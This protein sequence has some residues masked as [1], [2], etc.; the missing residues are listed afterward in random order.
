MYRHELAHI[1]KESTAVRRG[2]ELQLLNRRIEDV[3]NDLQINQV[4][5]LSVYELTDNV[6]ER[7]LRRSPLRPLR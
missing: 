3:L 1:P 6:L 7:V 5:T 2:E 4:V